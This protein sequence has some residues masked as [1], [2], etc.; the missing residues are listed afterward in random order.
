MKIIACLS[1]GARE[2]AVLLQVGEQQIL[3][4]VTPQHVQTLHIL[5]H[6]IDTGSNIKVATG[7]FTEKLQQMIKQQ[8]AK[9]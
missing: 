4:G 7:S 5:N 2:K 9:S 6:N 8:G 3:L 1:L